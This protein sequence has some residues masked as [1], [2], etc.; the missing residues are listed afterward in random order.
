MGSRELN[1]SSTSTETV[2]EERRVVSVYS[3]RETYTKQKEKRE[4]VMF[5]FFVFVEGGEFQIL[6]SPRGLHV[7]SSRTFPQPHVGVCS[8][9][10][11]ALAL[12][13]HGFGR[14]W[15]AI[16]LGGE[17]KAPAREGHR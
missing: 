10:T 16:C 7:P 5:F 11:D 6:P 15:K 12:L 3:Q 4:L 8:A 2:P 17:C 13:S 9:R 1:V 14:L